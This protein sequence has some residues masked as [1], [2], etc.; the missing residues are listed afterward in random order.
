MWLLGLTLN[1]RLA[2][3][4]ASAITRRGNGSK[5]RLFGLA[6]DSRE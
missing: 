4:A 3:H 5:V 1:G 6:T 2:K